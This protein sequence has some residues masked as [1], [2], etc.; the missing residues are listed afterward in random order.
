[1]G[2]NP[3]EIIIAGNIENFTDIDGVKLIDLKEESLSRKVATL[4]NTAADASTCDVIAWCDDDIILN[5]GWYNGSV[6]YSLKNGWDV[7]GCKILNP[8]GTRHWDRGTINPRKLVSYEYPSY[9]KNLLQTSGFLMVRRETF[10]KVRW[11]EDRLVYADRKEN[12]IPEDLQYS[13]D[14]ASAGYELSFNENSTVWHNDESYTEWGEQTLL[15]DLI[16]KQS[17]LG[18]FPPSC[19]EFL[20]QIG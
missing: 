20:E 18:F 12:Q 2:S 16:T 13:L 1:M 5:S 11:N 4:R 3:Y 6:D 7:L 15:K 17:G 10:Q 8:D 19:E 14:L 9:S